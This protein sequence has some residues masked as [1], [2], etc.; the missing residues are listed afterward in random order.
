MMLATCRQVVPGSLMRWC[1]QVLAPA[2][3]PGAFKAFSAVIRLL[4]NI[5]GGMSFVMLAKMFGVQKSSED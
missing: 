3:S 4:N 1:V 5:V 2:M